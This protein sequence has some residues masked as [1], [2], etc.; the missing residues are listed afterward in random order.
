VDSLS[1]STPATIAVDVQK[2]FD[3]RE[4]EIIFERQLALRPA[5]TRRFEGAF[6][7]SGDVPEYIVA[8]ELDPLVDREGE[9]NVKASL[10]DAYR[11][12]PGGYGSPT[13]PTITVVVQDGEPEAD[14]GAWIDVRNE[15]PPEPR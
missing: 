6:S 15:P 8:A 12:V 10:T 9:Y 14:F 13:R 11:F 3:D 5:S 4:D 1:T 7:T 2:N